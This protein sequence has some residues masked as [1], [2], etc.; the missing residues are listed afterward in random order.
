MRK[1]YEIKMR[2]TYKNGDPSG[3]LHT[4][5]S[6]RKAIDTQLKANRSWLAAKGHIETDV[7]IKAV[8]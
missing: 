1:H 3:V 7:E 8:S 6:S 4:T 2:F 5:V